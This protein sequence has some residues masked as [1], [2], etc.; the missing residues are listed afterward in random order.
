MG[1]DTDISN[2]ST[3]DINDTSSD[4]DIVVD[5][6]GLDLQA[7]YDYDYRSYLQTIINNQEKQASLNNLGFTY[8]I[9][10]LT[11]AFMY[12][13]IKNLIRK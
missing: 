7:Y 13:F 11:V 3:R 6:S 10:I 9:F 1:N 2:V 5:V 12:L 8:L 4:S